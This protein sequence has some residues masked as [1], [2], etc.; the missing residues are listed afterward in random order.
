[1]GY[2]GKLGNIAAQ[3]RECVSDRDNRSRSSN[4][5]LYQRTRH[6]MQ[7]GWL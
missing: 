7:D 2:F 6:L 1:M 4:E 3:I 5:E